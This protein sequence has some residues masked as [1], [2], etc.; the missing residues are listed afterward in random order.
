[1]PQST[2]IEG[3]AVLV[4]NL[5]LA[6]AEWVGESGKRAASPETEGPLSHQFTSLPAPSSAP[7]PPPTLVLPLLRLPV[8]KRAVAPLQGVAESMVSS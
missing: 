7:N 2:V 8:F 1:M 5:V 6:K 4:E 3:G